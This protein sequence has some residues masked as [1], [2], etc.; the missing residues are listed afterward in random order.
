M[1]VVGVVGVA[2]A[3]FDRS[4]VAAIAGDAVAASHTDGDCDCDD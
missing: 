1:L 3:G 4:T 2:V